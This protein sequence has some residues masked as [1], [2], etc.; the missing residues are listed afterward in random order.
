M[1]LRFRNTLVRAVFTSTLPL[2]AVSIALTLPA[3]AVDTAAS[4]KEQERA[5]IQLLKS[6][7]PPG[8]KAI[9]CKKLAIYGSEEAVPALAPL[10]ENEQLSSWALIALEAIPGSAPDNALRTAARKLHGG[11]LVGVID[12]IGVRRDAKSASLLARKLNDNDTQV[13]SA[14]AVSLGKIG[15][16]KAASTLRRALEK[17]NQPVRPAIAEGCIRCA[18]NLLAEGKSADA[19][20]LYDA[21]REASVPR[22]RVLEGLRGAI[23]ARGNAGIP[24]LL[25]Q[26]QS[27]ERD[28][29][30]LGLHVARELP[31]SAATAAVMGAFAQAAPD[32]QPLL[33]LALAERGDPAAMPVVTDAART[34]EKRLRL[35]AIEILDRA[36]DPS[37]LPVLLA[38]ATDDDPEISD[39][40]LAAVT[41]MAG[42][43]VD[44]ALVARLQES[45]SKMRRVLITLAARRGIQNAL[46]AVVQSVGD[47]DPDVRGAAVQALSAL[48]GENEVAVL[49]NALEKYENLAERARIDSVLVALSG[50]IGSKC[51]PPLL[52]LVQSAGLEN[53][54][55][56]LHALVA[57]GGSEA[58]AAVAAGTGDKDQSFQDEAV[59]A[60]CSWPDAWPEDSAVAGPLLQ[61]AKTDSNS[62]HQI[63]ALRGYLQF[64]LGDEKLDKDDKLAKLKEIMPLLQ[65]PEE[66]ITAIAVLQ[67]IPAPAALDLLAAFAAEP[68][69]ADDACS[70]L[71]QSAAQNKPSLSINQRQKA[72]QLALQQS[73]RE[74]TKQKAEKALKSL[75]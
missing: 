48:G 72:L 2:L 9:A 56:A 13:A 68:A 62:S 1:K 71:V 3:K 14:A 27:K 50:R 59:R 41:R 24:L 52:T 69:V 28:Y 32:R 21:V 44:S 58:L 7:A 60:L 35:V 22:E 18:E 4:A 39:A 17:A 29:F 54:K 8:D 12:S 65:R 34:G 26:L 16:H 31:G 30:N 25:D 33:L 23:L 55:I 38:D 40:S 66:K 51:V 10:L 46:P 67:G 64:L 49:A 57:A 45:S 42:G 61:T 73:T 36:G 37:T 53:R 63:L 75:Q 47:S 19:I 43:E 6:D 11:L 15:N 74:D 5:L 20:K 70:A